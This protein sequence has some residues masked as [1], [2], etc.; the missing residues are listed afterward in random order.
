M[1]G[2]ALTVVNRYQRP[3]HV[4]KKACAK[5]ETSSNLNVKIDPKLRSRIKLYCIAH[6]I[7]NW[8][9]V[10]GAPIPPPLGAVK[11]LKAKS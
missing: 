8:Q 10:D 5:E 3:S 7:G 11:S 6:S 1:A 4:G 2:I 9:D